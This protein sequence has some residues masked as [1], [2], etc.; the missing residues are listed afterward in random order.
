MGERRVSCGH[1]RQGTGLRAGDASHLRV[2]GSG[3]T[4]L[5]RLPQAPLMGGSR[6]RFPPPSPLSPCTPLRSPCS[7]CHHVAW[8]D[9]RSGRCWG[10]TMPPAMPTIFLPERL[11]PTHSADDRS[12]QGQASGAVRGPFGKGWPVTR[13]GAAL[14]R[15]ALWLGTLAGTHRAGQAATGAGHARVQRLTCLPRAAQSGA[16]GAAARCFSSSD[17]CFCSSRTSRC[18][19]STS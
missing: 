15:S 3:P 14:L 4:S 18:T 2:Q 19:W 17:I 6:G 7:S 5:H 8:R 9:F 13:W 12:R 16:V 10:K 11:A 1:G